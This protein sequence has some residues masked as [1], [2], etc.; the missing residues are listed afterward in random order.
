MLLH[1]LGCLAVMAVGCADHGQSPELDPRMCVV[2]QTVDRTDERFES[3]MEEPGRPSA[4]RWLRDGV[5]RSSWTYAYDDAGRLVMQEQDWGEA[6]WTAP[7]VSRIS[8]SRSSTPR[9]W[10]SRRGAT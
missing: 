8:M 6:R 2:T 4:T 7:T 1:H 5:V 3:Q 9:R 10:R